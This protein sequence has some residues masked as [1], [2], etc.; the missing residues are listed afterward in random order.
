[1]T[2]NQIYAA[3][4]NMQIQSMDKLK[5][6]VLLYEGAINFMHQAKKHIKNKNYAEKGKYIGK[7][8][9]ILIE[10]CSSL[11]MENGGEIALNLSRLYDYVLYQL[12]MAN[13]KNKTEFVDHAISTLETILHAW[14]KISETHKAPATPG[15]TSEHFRANAAG[16]QPNQQ[17]A[18]AY[19]SGGSDRFTV[20]I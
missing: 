13:L 19:G 15:N 6:V 18:R 1:M 9:D 8:E 16:A 12:T 10:L 4:E 7:A 2:P 14:K 17:A 5:I 20:K 3:Y 11:D